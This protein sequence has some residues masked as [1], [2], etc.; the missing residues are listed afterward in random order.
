[1]WGEKEGTI[2]STI[3]KKTRIGRLSARLHTVRSSS[4]LAYLSHRSTQ[5]LAL[6]LRL[7]FGFLFSGGSGGGGSCCGGGRMLI[8]FFARP[9]VPVRAAEGLVC[10]F[11]PRG[12]APERPRR[13]L[14]SCMFAS[15]TCKRSIGPCGF[16]IY[17]WRGAGVRERVLS[18]N[19]ENGHYCG[20][21]LPL[22]S[23]CMMF[24]T[25][26]HKEN[27]SCNYDE[28]HLAKG[29]DVRAC[30]RP[31]MDVAVVSR[32]DKEIQFPAIVGAMHGI[33]GCLVG[34]PLVHGL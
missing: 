31:H 15:F 5:M 29:P 24:F 9:A 2:D 25:R 33:N 4:L 17:K 6:S 23:S 34:L 28:P 11:P 14:F 27:C 7:C 21:P 26:S 3:K 16:I 10:R 19:R 8:V 1:M 30:D 20:A 32:C 18:F 22:E 13:W 12:A